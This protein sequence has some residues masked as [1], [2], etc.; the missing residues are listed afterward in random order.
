MDSIF[1][2]FYFLNFFVFSLNFYASYYLLRK[3]KYPR[4]KA[5]A[6]ASIISIT[7]TPKVFF[8]FLIAFNLDTFSLSQLNSSSAAPTT[9]LYASSVK[10]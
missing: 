6:D 10:S 7:V 2:T 4:A 9:S 3:A 8:I 5:K 1:E